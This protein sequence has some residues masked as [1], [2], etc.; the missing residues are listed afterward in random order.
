MLLATA[1]WRPVARGTAQP[2]AR[3]YT[4]VVPTADVLALVQQ[5]VYTDSGRAYPC[6][7]NPACSSW[8]QDLA[9]SAPTLTVEGARLVAT[10]HVTGTYAISQFF[11]PEVSGDLYISAIPVV[12]GNMIRLT[13]TK[14][15]PGPGDMTFRTFIEAAHTHMEQLLNQRATFD[16]AQYLSL[17][18]RDSRLPPPRLPDVR[19]ID[20][21]QITVQSVATQ[22][23]PPAVVAKVSVR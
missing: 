6:R 16:L 11:E 20:A 5:L 3:P 21:S 4:L 17:A 12:A 19:N 1:S 15:E 13:D 22:V 7:N 18:S 8:G 10:T 23:G 2:A 14:I 9:L